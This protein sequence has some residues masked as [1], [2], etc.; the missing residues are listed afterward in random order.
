[1]REF[2]SEFRGLSGTA[3]QKQV[4]AQAGLDRAYLHDLVAGGQIDRAAVAR[5]LAAMQQLS[6]PV[7][8]EALGVLG[9]QH[10]RHRLGS[11]ADAPSFRYKRLSGIDAQGLPYVVECAFGITENLSLQGTHIGVN[12]SV[13]LT[14]PLKENSFDG[15]DGERVWGLGGLLESN[16]IDLDGD[17]IFLALHLICPQFRF[18]DRGKGSVHLPPSF[19]QAV[20]KAV[21]DT[22]KEWAAIK[23]KEER[24]HRQ[25]E[26]LKERLSHVRVEHTS[27]KD[28]AY[29]AIPDA[30]QKAS[31]NGRYPA[32]AR[33]IMYAARPAIQEATGEALKDTYFTQ[34][35]LPDYI[36]EH[37]EETAGWDVVYDAR[38]HLWE[39]H[40]GVEIGLGTIGVRGYLA[41]MEDATADGT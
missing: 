18:L 1:M 17:P 21:L 5:L 6:A 39:P 36:L 27:V 13:P 38:G 37:P 30:Y 20:G 8:P 16:H 25:A 24:D 40:T 7:K 14:N 2:A 12:W 33:Q 19:A 23:K 4:T 10:F 32:N 9:E 28:A 15:A 31:G 34:T 11:G 41:D 35:L 29:A 3:K 26:R 22:T